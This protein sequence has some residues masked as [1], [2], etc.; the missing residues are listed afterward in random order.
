MG[1]LAFRNIAICFCGF[2]LGAASVGCGNRLGPSQAVGKGAKRGK[3]A[4]VAA[5]LSAS[6]SVGPKRG[7]QRTA[8]A[9][10][11]QSQPIQAQL[12]L[13]QARAALAS[14]KTIAATIHERIHL[15]GQELVGKGDFFQAPG[16]NLLKLD[17]TLNVDGR[18]FYVQQR[19][20]GRY[21]WL[22]KCV[23]GVPRVTRVDVRQVEAAR[24][25]HSNKTGSTTA[26]VTPV[27]DT[28]PML[29][30]GGS[31]TLL[32]QLD[33]WCD[34]SKVSQVVLRAPGECPV[35]MLEGTWKQDRMLFW[36]P[37]QKTAFEEGRPFNVARLPAMLPDRVILFLGRDDLFPRR[38][39]YGVS[40]SRLGD[41]QERPPLVRIHFEDVEFDQSYDPND[42]TFESSVAA[43]VDD[44]DGYLLRHGWQ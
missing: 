39:D 44:T 20:D 36:L 12:L 29:G 26:A 40:E 5:G 30:L 43:P 3:P 38:I 37:D 16:R 34:F 41:D 15:Y 8:Q 21:Y 9:S 10:P 33:V 31:A 4:G 22:Q 24:A 27:S 13:R 42:F 23:D 18:D 28:L 19:C 32:E 35:Y 7:Q 1:F 11:P 6:A 14:H 17:L 2:V 25:A